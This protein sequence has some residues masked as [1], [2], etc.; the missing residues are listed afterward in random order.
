MSFSG[1]NYLAVLAA[2]VA[3]FAF[4]AAWYMTLSRAW[5][6]A[7][8]LTREQLGKPSPLPFVVS[9]V[10]L[11]VMAWVLAGML[12]HFGSGQVTVRNGIVSG[13]FLWLGFVITTLAV[14]NAYGQRKL[15]LTVI[16]GLHWLGVLVVQG[17]V[18]GAMGLR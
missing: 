2:A 10:A 15:S 18:I 14:N 6:A 4:G 8:G 9:F 16:D 3:A 11:L 1:V 5:L 17:A 12:A 7:V 13:L